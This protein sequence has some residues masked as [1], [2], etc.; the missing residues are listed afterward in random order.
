MEFV[1]RRRE[2]NNEY[3][4]SCFIPFPRALNALPGLCLCRL[5]PGIAN[6]TPEEQGKHGIF[7]QMAAFAK[8]VMNCI[9]PGLRQMGKE[10]VKY[11]F[12][13]VRRVLIRT[14]IG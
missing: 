13:Q 12:K 2:K 8:D 1:K 4:Q 5:V 14:R 7:A 9:D 6:G 10:P 3:C 11:R